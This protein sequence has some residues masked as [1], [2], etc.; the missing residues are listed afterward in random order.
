MTV[1]DEEGIL[2]ALQHRHRICRIRLSIPA[3]N[4]WKLVAAIDGEFQM[5]EYLFIKPLNNDDQSLILPE[6][7]HAPHLRHV[8]LRNVT[9]SP[10]M[11]HIPPPTPRVQSAEGIDRG[12]LSSVSQPWRLRGTFIHIL[13]EDSLLNIFHLYRPALLDEAEDNDTRILQ[14]GKWDRE[15][16]WYKLTHV[17]RPWRYL[18]LASAFHLGLSLV[19]T[20]GTPVKDML[21]HSPPLPLT[22]D[23]ID[24]SHNITA[25]DEEGIMLALRHRD[26]VRR[27]RLQIPVPNLQKLLMTINDEFPM[28]EYLYIRPPAKD[29]MGLILPKTFQAPQLR[30]FVL[31]NFAFSIRS[32]LLTTA[33]GLVTLSLN[34]IHPSAYFRPNDLLQRLSLMPQLEVL[35]I[36]FHSPVPNRDIKMVLSGT[37]IMTHVTL[38]NLRWFGFTGVSAFLEAL[39][40]RMTTPLLEKIQIA[41]FNQLTFSVPHLLQYVGTTESLRFSSAWIG[42]FTGRVVMMVYPHDGAKMYTLYLEVGCGHLD[43]QVAS[44]A[45]IFSALR[46][47]F[48]TV[49]YLTLDYWRHSIGSEWHKEADRTQWHELLREVSN[50][51]TL[52]VDVGLVTQLS[53]ALQLDDVES[54]TDLLP[55]LKEL[56]CSTTGDAEDAFTMFIDARQRAGRPVTL[57][58]REARLAQ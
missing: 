33:T 8:A 25:E 30:Y 22:I 41:F 17:C 4:L 36:S 10:G 2:V 12:A 23:Y 56:S 50:V 13:N 21:A 54:P 49:E 38:P 1:D 31:E 57:T 47:A 58:S 27:I 37:P 15:R 45:Q 7:F 53:R 48:S 29:G 18:V 24:Q 39:L 19:C 51:K 46:T 35:G 26:R 16:W 44:A 52:R 11:S 55:E 42:F 14:G 34:R 28:L 40:S 9:Y 6:T 20:Y 5:L 3:S 32:P 43:W